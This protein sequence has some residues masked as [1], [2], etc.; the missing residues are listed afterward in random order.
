[1]TKIQE[2]GDKVL[3]NVERVIVG[4]H[5]EV[6]LALVALLCRGHLLI[7]DVPGTGKTV[8]AKAI[9][10]SLGGSFRRIQFTP[11]LLPSDVSGLSI[12]NQKTQEFEF[13]PGP[14]FSQVVLADEI[15]RATPK[16]QSALLECM[17]ERQATIDGTTYPMPDPFLVIATQNPIE[18][19][20][21]FALPE[22]QL[23]RFMLRLR[24]GYPQP[25]E[26]I[27]I[28]D[29]Q[30]RTHPLDDLEE[31][32]TVDD[33]REMQSADPRDLR[34]LD[35]LGLHRPAGQRDPDPRR[36]LPR[37]LAARFDRALSRGPGAGR[38]ARSRLRDPRR[39]EGPRGAGPR[40]PPHHQDELV[41]PRRPG[42]PGRPRAPRG[43]PDRGH[44]ADRRGTEGAARGGERVLDGDQQL[45][46]RIERHG[47]GARQVI[48][49]LELL[50]VAVILVVAAFST[51]LPFLFYLLYL[52][53]LVIGGS[54][55]LV[56]L[57]LTDLEAGYAVSA[58][59][60]HV[61][62]RMRVTYTLRNGSRM[63]KLWLEI[64]NP[65]TL[66][67]GLPGRAITL[68]GRSERSWLIRAPLSRRGHFR[69]E[70]LHIRTGDPFGFF[71]ASATVGQGISVVVY[72][73]IEPLPRWRLPS[74]A[75]EGSH[76]SPVR[77]L[78]TTP[79]ATSVRPYAPGDA[80][81]RIH[82]KTTARHGE[83]QV[84]EFDLEQTADAW[85]VLDLQ[86]GIQTGR[87]DDSTVE[88]AVR[89]AASIA[90]R[91]LQENRAV[92]MTVNAGRTAFIPADRGGRQHLK[93]MQLLA[94]VEADGGTP[95]GRGAHHDRRS[96]PARDDRGDH[97]R[98]ARP[99]V[100]PSARSPPRPGRGLRRGDARRGGVREAGDRA[101]RRRGR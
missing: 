22:A 45:A 38:P 89:A 84:K 44:P 64:H 43:D 9:A 2:T 36:C 68:G 48:R 15:N 100:G 72:P 61:G 17:E 25:I 13:R 50:I 95:S 92:G 74:A 63:P 11:D 76:A 78:Q 35:R 26:E 77:T 51:A 70:P 1:M 8:L 87:G 7:E 31:V 94:A 58:L 47:G 75:L 99:G 32:L 6:R 101:D 98:L 83:I 54:Y 57:G 30:K 24:L 71:E 52:A 59:H 80:M 3:A 60:G 86:R 67:G 33:L 16:T 79:M 88:T 65:T 49:K 19:E 90:D 40:P 41:D 37:R 34:R 69:I 29:E 56:R 55:V 42:R 96:P 10:R 21:T 20:G 39:R 14:I 81:N 82:W 85:I 91:A 28:L 66:P 62:D 18:Y 23:D 73:R 12:Y 4:K 53:I 97:H 27:V 46:D 93:I 5:H